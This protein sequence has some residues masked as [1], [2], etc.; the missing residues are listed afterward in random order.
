M[1]VG[2]AFSILIHLLRRH[3]TPGAACLAGTWPKYLA[4]GAVALRTEASG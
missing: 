3:D 1:D 2:A 4:E